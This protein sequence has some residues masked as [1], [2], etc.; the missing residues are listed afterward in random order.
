M[1]PADSLGQ[2]KV[3]ESQVS[4]GQ[5]GSRRQLLPPVAYVFKSF[6]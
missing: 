5:T 3:R 6:P 4:A 1:S 2:V